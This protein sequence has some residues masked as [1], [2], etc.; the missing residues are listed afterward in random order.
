MSTNKP[1]TR[2]TDE[3]LAEICRFVDRYL[4]EHR[5]AA[6][7]RDV[8]EFLGL[9]SSSTAYHVISQCKGLGVAR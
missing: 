4:K 3:E 5:Y 1:F 7:V 2:R 8:M 6:S 9:E